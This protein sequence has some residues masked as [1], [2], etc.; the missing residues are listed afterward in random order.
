MDEYKLKDTLSDNAGSSML[1]VGGKP[2]LSAGPQAKA[3]KDTLE[4]GHS[5]LVSIQKS[6]S[7]F[8]SKITPSFSSLLL[9]GIQYD[10]FRS[11]DR[12][13]ESFNELIMG[14][15]IYMHESGSGWMFSA[16][17]LM[18]EISSGGSRIIS[19]SVTPNSDVTNLAGTLEQAS[20]QIKSEY[21]R[22]LAALSQ[23][24][25]KV[26]RLRFTANDREIKSYHDRVDIFHLLMSS[27]DGFLKI[28]FGILNNVSKGIASKATFESMIR[29][30]YLVKISNDVHDYSNRLVR[31]VFG[32]SPQKASNRSKP[33]KNKSTFKIQDIVFIKIP[34]RNNWISGSN[35]VHFDHANNRS[36]NPGLIK[37]KTDKDY[38]DNV[39]SLN[40]EELTGEFIAALTNQNMLEITGAYG[41]SSL[42][43]PDVTVTALSNSGEFEMKFDFD[44]FKNKGGSTKFYDVQRKPPPLPPTSSDPVMKVV[45][46]FKNKNGDPVKIN[47]DDQGIFASNLRDDLLK[48]SSSAQT[49]PLYSTIH[50]GEEVIFAPSSLV[51]NMGK[52]KTKSGKLF[53]PKKWKAKGLSVI[54]NK[55]KPKGG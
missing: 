5:E 38:W 46:I 4:S 20:L 18:K 19:N 14:N 51:E 40:P 26:G 24:L 12:Y 52:V 50:E 3:Y 22:S 36:S 1:G 29:M 10:D 55:W 31:Y 48:F 25:P 42:S 41:V 45:F 53:K 13:K 27:N 6:F 43:Y 44:A 17:T 32:R 16:E 54:V 2:I 7:I 34:G 35:P 49:Q 11:F 47:G 28:A 33:G 39:S 37:I 15:L 9:Q 30:Y 21:N 23:E 8:S